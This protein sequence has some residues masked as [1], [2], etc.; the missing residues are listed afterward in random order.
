MIEPRSKRVIA[1]KRTESVLNDSY[2]NVGLRIFE[3]ARLT[4]RTLVAIT[5]TRLDIFR[6]Q[7]ECAGSLRRAHD[8]NGR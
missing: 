5:Q 6:S 7:R 1:E 3:V 2:S 4:L 8:T